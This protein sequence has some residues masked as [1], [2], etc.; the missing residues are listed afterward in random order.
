M[1]NK[2]LTKKQYWDAMYGAAD[3]DKD[4][5]AAKHGFIYRFFYRYF[6]KVRYGYAGYLLFDVMY[7]KYLPRG[8]QKIIEI[9]SAP[10]GNLIIMHENFGYVPYGVEY[11]EARVEI[12]RQ[13]FENYG[14]DP[15]KI[16]HS[17]FFDDNF[18]KKY[19]QYF[20]IVMSLTA[21]MW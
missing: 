12:N 15:G 18:Q 13:L 3:K 8:E 19:Q 16:I 14:L 6:H 10:G 20:D 1:N 11:T 2:K 9:G 17:D 7:R 4:L 5:P 21:G